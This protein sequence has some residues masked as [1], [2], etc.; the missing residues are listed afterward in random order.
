LSSVDECIGRLVV[1]ARHQE[2]T[3]PRAPPAPRPPPE[4]VAVP[5]RITKMESAPK[6]NVL[7]AVFI[8]TVLL[9][10]AFHLV[11]LAVE[12]P[13]AAPWVVVGELDSGRAYLAPSGPDVG[14]AGLA[15]TIRD[16]ENSGVSVTH[17]ANGEWLLARK[18][19]R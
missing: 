1:L 9:G 17:A 5:T 3:T 12:P 7:R 15:G 19:S 13:R 4:P 10:A 8:S 2:R 14:A 6:R 18:A 16:L 11:R